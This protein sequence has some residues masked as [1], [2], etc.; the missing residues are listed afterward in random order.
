MDLPG[1]QL[2]SS[3][4][5]SS[6]KK[7]V[8]RSD[9]KKPKKYLS[10]MESFSF[11][12]SKKDLALPDQMMK[13]KSIN[14]SHQVSK[15]S[16]NV[17]DQNNCYMFTEK[18]R[19]LFSK[20]GH[21]LSGKANTKGSF[22]IYSQVFNELADYLIEFK[23]ILMVLKEGLVLSGIKE[24]D[25]SDFEYKRNLNNTQKDL[26][27]LLEKERRDKALL[28]NKLNKLSDDYMELKKTNESLQKKYSEYE[29]IIKNDPNKFIEAEKLLEKMMSQCEIIRKQQDFIHELQHSEIKM[30]KIIEICEKKGF[31]VEE[32]LKQSKHSVLN[33]GI[34]KLFKKSNT[35]TECTNKKLD[36]SL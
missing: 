13:R 20:L 32:V 21:L 17:R 15:S 18:S 11:A 34:L 1:I 5:L 29:K 3:Y 6:Q 12:P 23:D 14:C 27:E 36:D 31:V 30:K 2:N 4:S 10:R 28:A 9:S 33:P 7:V 24:K 8:V 35:L 26:S 19:Q 22:H 25:F 16:N